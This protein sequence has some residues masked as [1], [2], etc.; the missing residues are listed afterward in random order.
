M[1]TVQEYLTQNPFTELAVMQME[2]NFKGL[3]KRSGG[4]EVLYSVTS[5]ES[6]IVHTYLGCL[7]DFWFLGI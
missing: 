1:V 5:V 7:T 4:T 3:G 6:Y 2:L